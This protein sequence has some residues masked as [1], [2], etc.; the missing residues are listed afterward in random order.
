M[1][2]TFDLSLFPSEIIIEVLDHLQFPEQLHLSA[3]CRRFRALLLRDVFAKLRFSDNEGASFVL[4]AVKA[5]GDLAHAI[6]YELN[7][8]SVEDLQTPAL[9]PVA[10]EVLS[11]RWTPNAH[12]VRLKLTFQFGNTF[13]WA[14]EGHRRPFEYGDEDSAR[15]ELRRLWPVLVNETWEAVSYNTAVSSLVVEGFFPVL[16]A[17]CGSRKFVQ[18]M[19]Q[20]KSI[21]FVLGSDE[22]MPESW[23]T[24]ECFRTLQQVVGWHFFN[25]M[26]FLESLCFDGRNCLLGLEDLYHAPLPLNGV[27]LVA[28]R[29]LTLRHCYIDLRLARFL[30]R[31][32]QTLTHLSLHNCYASDGGPWGGNASGHVSWVD[33]FDRIYR[34]AP[35]LVSL[36]VGHDADWVTKEKWHASQ[37]DI[38]HRDKIC[39]ALQSDFHRR[40]FCYVYMDWRTGRYIGMNNVINATAYR[41]E[42][43]WKAYQRLMELVEVNAAKATSAYEVPEEYEPVQ[44]RP[45]T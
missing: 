24:K 18:F 45:V 23:T 12:T 21:K 2:I 17:A 4:A 3:T 37:D 8:F 32:S 27:R 5:H 41:D 28:L 42:R 11:G 44:F 15:E 9:S 36:V 20:I 14:I 16:F 38:R 7:A 35:V 6:E 10:V 19:R 25:H 39:D 13:H 34:T 30:H 40:H 1:S 33:F 22:L 43:D 29:K 31:H 26:K